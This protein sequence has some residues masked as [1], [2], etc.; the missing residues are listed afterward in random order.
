MRRTALIV[1]VALA[2]PLLLA[3]CGGSNSSSGTTTD[4]TG[5]TAKVKP[6]EVAVKIVDLGCDPGVLNLPA[7]P[8]TF[9]VTNDGA[10]KV[11]EPS[12]LLRRSYLGDVFR[13]VDPFL[14]IAKAL[15]EIRKLLD[16]IQDSLQ[17]GAGENKLTAFA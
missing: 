2:L 3:A 9:K 13:K 12:A 1:A 4:A 15:L 16:V 8:T 5:S 6:N 14:T 10:S 7:G 17:V 11:T